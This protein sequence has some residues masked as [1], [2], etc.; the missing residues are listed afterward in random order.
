VGKSKINSKMLFELRNGSIIRFA[1][2]SRQY[3]FSA[4]LTEEQILAKFQQESSDEGCEGDPCS[5][6][7][8]INTSLN[9]KVSCSVDSSDVGEPLQK[10]T[11][12]E[13][14]TKKTV[15]FSDTDPSVIPSVE[16]TP[17]EDDGLVEIMGTQGVTGKFSSLISTETVVSVRKPAKAISKAP[18]VSAAERRRRQALLMDHTR[19]MMPVVPVQHAPIRA[20]VQVERKTDSFQQQSAAHEVEDN[21]EGPMDLRKT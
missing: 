9:S 7:V 21:D 2:S 15:R 20:P 19:S 13:D 3:I 8:C 1:G 18:A 11:R 16:Q 6:E 4:F 10:R 12:I 5:L 14:S 17:R